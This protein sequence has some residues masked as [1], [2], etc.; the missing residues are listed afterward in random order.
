MSI[1]KFIST[2]YLKESTSIQNNVDDSLLEPYIIKVQDTH[3]QQVLGSSFMAHL[4]DAIENST[5]TAVE[6]ALIR[7]YIQRTVAEWAHYEVYPFLNYKNTNKAI[8]KESSE[9]SV[10]AELDE[11][12]Y[13]RSAIRDM[14]EFYSTR[15]AKYLCD[16]QSDFPEYQNPDLPENLPR[17]NKSYFNGIYIERKGPKGIQS[18]DEPFSE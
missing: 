17:N 14:A 18:Y 13:M 2:Q 5:L 12:K 16:H 9:Y 7:N 3:I 6:E 11:I 1:V 15:L 4:Y 8:S 10:P